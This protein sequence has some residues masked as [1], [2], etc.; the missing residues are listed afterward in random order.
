[1][2]DCPNFHSGKTLYN[3]FDSA[4]LKIGNLSYKFRFRYIS[5]T[6]AMGS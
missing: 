6:I 2:D 1:M 4:R 3:L 5:Q